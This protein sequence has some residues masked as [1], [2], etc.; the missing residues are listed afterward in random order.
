MDV[1]WKHAHA[2]VDV[3]MTHKAKFEAETS[4]ER[5]RQRN[6]KYSRL[7]QNPI[8]TLCKATRTLPPV[9]MA[10]GSELALRPEKQFGGESKAIIGGDDGGSLEYSAFGECSIRVA[11][12]RASK[13][14]D[15]MRRADLIRHF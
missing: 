3:N 9:A 14:D 1:H 4:T 6:L 7:R 10:E 12:Q 11:T 5:R 8:S 15:Q 2:Q 13:D